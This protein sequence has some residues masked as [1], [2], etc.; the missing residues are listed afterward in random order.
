MEARKL[1]IYLYTK[2]EGVYDKIMK[3]IKDKEECDLEKAEKE[4][5]EFLEKHKV[6]T[7]IDDVEDPTGLSGLMRRTG[8]VK[9]PFIIEYDGDIELAKDIVEGKVVA[10]EEVEMADCLLASGIPVARI[11]EAEAYPIKKG[12]SKKARVS[13]VVSK[14]DEITG[15]IR[16]LAIFEGENED[17]KGNLTI[18]LGSL[19]KRVLISN[20]EDNNGKILVTVTVAQGNELYAVPGKSGSTTNKLIKEGAKLCDT[21]EDFKE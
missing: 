3:A 7:L 11:I 14:K 5:K 2:Y 1:L 20:G 19:F 10:A 17:A 18:R 15:E 4:V 21:P 16:N 9:P 8:G 12:E 6:I 13:M